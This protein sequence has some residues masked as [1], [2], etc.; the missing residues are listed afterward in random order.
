MPSNQDLTQISL[1]HDVLESVF[2]LNTLAS[3]EELF[4]CLFKRGWF[5]E[6]KKHS[7]Y[8]TEEH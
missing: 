7:Q 5:K 8:K 4:L 2:D 1:K 6:E 3:G